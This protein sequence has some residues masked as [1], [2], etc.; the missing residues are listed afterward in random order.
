MLLARV[1]GVTLRGCPGGASQRSPVLV[2]VVVL[3]A[4]CGVCV[5]HFPRV[6][7]AAACARLT[8]HAWGVLGRVRAALSATRVRWGMCVVHFPRL[9]SAGACAWWTFR[10]SGVLGRVPGALSAH[11][12]SARF[13]LSFP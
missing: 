3:G 12:I 8:F 7:R 5:A 11:A 4:C 13:L 6:G 10:G 9:G 2:D 1:G